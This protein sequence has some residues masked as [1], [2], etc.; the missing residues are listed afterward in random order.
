M[1]RVSFKAFN[2]V[3]VKMHNKQPDDK[4]QGYELI[5]SSIPTEREGF[6]QLCREDLMMEH[7]QSHK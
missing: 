7:K 5:M 6:S 1:T 4:R 2:V 3:T